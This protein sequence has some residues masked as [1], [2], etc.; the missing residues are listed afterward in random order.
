MRS[1]QR[2]TTLDPVPGHIV[3]T[4]RRIDL[5]AGREARFKDEAP[6]I[7][8]GLS[9]TTRV[10]SITASSAIEGVLVAQGRARHLADASNPRPRNRSESEFAGY[11]AALDYLNRQDPGP[12]SVGLIL[13][14]HRLL[15]SLAEA[16]GGLFK[17]DENVVIDRNP[18]GTRTVRF[19]PVSPRDTPFFVEELTART[20]TCLDEGSQHPLVIIGAFALDL[21]C[22]HPFSDGNGRVTRLAS[23]F[24]LAECGYGVGRYVSLE[25]L[26]YDTRSTYYEALAA[27]TA[28]WFDDASH[29]VWPWL[30]YFLARLAEG[31]ERFAERM[32]G[33][34]NGGKQHRVRDYVLARAPASFTIADVRRAMPGISDNTIRI[35]LNQLRDAGRIRI[36]GTGRGAR[37]YRR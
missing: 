20:R 25:Q 12:L 19:R 1:F 13:H 26:I 7:L 35:V 31:Y 37:W 17:T 30:S 34:G 28:G 9:Q 16:P 21:L 4:L 24:L 6:Q 23:S 2:S 5:A 14:L 29:D 27:S 32:A 10:E 22:I 33:F 18:D 11:A 8:A 36:D 15:F 3:G